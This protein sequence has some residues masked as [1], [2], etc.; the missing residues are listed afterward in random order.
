MIKFT[1]IKCSKSNVPNLVL[2]P[3]GPGLS[4]LSIRGF[5]LLSKSFNLF[6]VDFPGTNG[7]PYDKDRSFEELSELLLNKVKSITGETY[8][9]GHSFG[10]F[11]A[12]DVSLWHDVAGIICVA[13]P[14]SSASLSGANANYKSKMT[15]SLKMAEE[16]FER[17]STDKTFANWLAEYGELYFA[18]HSQESGRML[19]ANDPCSV[20]SFL[21]NTNDSKNMELLL[22]KISEL[23]IKK[24]FIAASEDGLINKSDLKNDATRGLFEFL[25]I[26]NANHFVMLD[27]AEIVASVIEKFIATNKR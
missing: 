16:E 22:G 10:G 8:L 9:I 25:E 20:K 24:L 4:S 7:N 3:G 2:I 6:Y 26:N 17:S 14:F 27:Q 11:F 23:G 18:P 1:E 12:A 15:P 5:D 19:M 13:T 21:H